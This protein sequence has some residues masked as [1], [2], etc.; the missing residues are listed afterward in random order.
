MREA[1]PRLHA[2]RAPWPVATSTLNT[3]FATYPAATP[4]PPTPMP[5]TLYTHDN[6]R[7]D[8]RGIIRPHRPPPLYRPPPPYRPP[9]PYHPPAPLHGYRSGSATAFHNEASS[10]VIGRATEGTGSPPS[11]LLFR[12]WLVTLLESL[13]MV[14]SRYERALPSGMEPRL[15]SPHAWNHACTPLRHGTTHA[16]A[17]P[18]QSGAPSGQRRAACR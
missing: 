9:S 8:V 1:R 12:L 7:T 2:R 15:H 4:L 17:R 10:R 11:A 5:P 3:P 16:A 14:R 6:I 13:G 18:E